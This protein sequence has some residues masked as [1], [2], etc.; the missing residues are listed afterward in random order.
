MDCF[1]TATAKSCGILK[2]SDSK[3]ELMQKEKNYY[4][5][6]QVD[7]GAEPDVISAAYKRLSVK[8]HPD[9]NPA[10]DANEKMQELNE[11][12]QVL[13]DPARRRWYD[14]SLTHTASYTAY[15]PPPNGRGAAVSE[16]KKQPPSGL[17]R[18]IISLT[19]PITYTL[20]FFLLTRIF[21]APVLFI[22]ALVL[23][24]I[25]AYYITRKVEAVLTQK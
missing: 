22:F 16:D 23:A 12:Y 20:T 15:Q 9:R 19:F 2:S 6:L 7:P 3:V 25:F 14:A 4:Q 10:L 11:A 5:V 1:H 13:M 8:Y 18:M 24:G 17:K 21:R